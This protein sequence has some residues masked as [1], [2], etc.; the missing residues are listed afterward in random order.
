MYQCGVQ[1]RW[2]PIRAQDLFSLP[3]SMIR[4]DPNFEL[5]ADEPSAFVCPRDAANPFIWQPT[6]S[7]GLTGGPLYEPISA[8]I[9]RVPK[10]K[11]L[12]RRKVAKREIEAEIEQSGSTKK[13]K[14]SA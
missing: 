1:C 9:A 3:K 7:P 10:K 13:Q 8:I 12:P 14:V 6:G 11:V 5:P 2:R 4:I